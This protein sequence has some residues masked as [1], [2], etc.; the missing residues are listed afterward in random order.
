[1]ETGDKFGTNVAIN[2]ENKKLNCSNNRF[3]DQKRN[4]K[5][6]YLVKI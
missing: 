5:Y 3:G 2:S 4:K 1:M 6:I